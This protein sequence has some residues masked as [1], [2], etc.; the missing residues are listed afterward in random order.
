M[1]P[2]TCSYDKHFVVHAVD[3]KDCKHYFN[4]ATDYYFCFHARAEAQRRG[5]SHHWQPRLRACVSHH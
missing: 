5:L 4:N 2:K 3:D 1:I